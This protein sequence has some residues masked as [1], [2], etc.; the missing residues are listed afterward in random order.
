[1]KESFESR[2]EP[3]EIYS[4]DDGA[5]LLG[6]QKI[7]RSLGTSQ[8]KTMTHANVAERF[9]RSMKKGIGDCMHFTNGKW[10]DMLKPALKKYNDT[11]HSSTGMKPTEAHKDENG[12]NVKANLTLK[13]KHM[14][15]Y[16]PLFRSLK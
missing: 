11:I 1:M 3:T 9:I 15:K 10:T 4:D 12:I 5:F 8:K 6:C 7:F 14:R 13:Q 16:Q 2:G